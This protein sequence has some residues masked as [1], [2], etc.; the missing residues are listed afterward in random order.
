MS[1]KLWQSVPDKTGRPQLKEVDLT[2]LTIERP[3]LVYL[4][5]FLTNNDRPDFIAGSIKRIDEL[6]RN[7]PSSAVVPD[8]YAWSH[9]GLSNL[10]NL[11]AYDTFPNSRA[12][13]AGYIL[14]ANIL[15][16]LVT[17]DFAVFTDGAMV[18]RPRPLEEAA[19]KL[20]NVTFFGYSAGS[21]VAQETFNA[22]KKM[23]TTIG[24]TE[25]EVRQLMKEVVLINAG[26]ISR[27]SQEK[28]RYTTINM[29]A[30][31]DRI[32]RC[33]NWVWGTAGTALRTVFTRYAWEKN[34]KD[35]SI[36]PLSPS[37]LFVNAAVKADLYEW[38]S[39]EKGIR[40]KRKVNPLF[41]AWTFSR[42][43][44]ELPHYI[45]KDDTNNGF[46]RIA[47]YATVNAVSRTSLVKP[48]SLLDPPPG[49]VFSKEDQAAY[50]E[51]IKRALKPTPVACA[52]S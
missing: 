52:R 36:R 1:G 8:I 23:M 29:I 44:H 45:T 3:A 9:K 24:F 14:A 6:L 51:R 10:F 40:T 47:L 16:P 18:G 33:K 30:S 5:G 13:E 2:R 37:S 34:T 43:Y 38:V 15:M 22:A 11:A 50:R 35:L 31:N 41:P 20:R 19:K 48:L 17:E 21:I 27:P 39:N 28:D 12:S 4:S 46:S 25:S 26:C 42:S 49:D 32:N 7:A